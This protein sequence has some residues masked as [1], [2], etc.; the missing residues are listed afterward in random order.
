MAE[1]E[2]A[3]ANLKEAYNIDSTNSIVIEELSK[4]KELLK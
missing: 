4:V 3:L 1:L 2:E